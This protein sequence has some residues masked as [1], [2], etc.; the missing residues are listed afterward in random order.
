MKQTFNERVYALVRRI[1]PGRVMSYGGV[2]QL[3]NVPRGARAVGWALSALR[4]GTDVPWYRVINS[5]RKISLPVDQPSGAIQ[6]SLL[7]GEGIT[8]DDQVIPRHFMLY[9][10]DELLPPAKGKKH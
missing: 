4:D 9:N 8:F 10:E 1:P 2:A 6:R 5:S 7:E 3:L